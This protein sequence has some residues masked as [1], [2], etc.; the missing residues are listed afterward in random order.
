[1]LPGV[2]RHPT[3]PIR[4]RSGTDFGSGY[5]SDRPAEPVTRPGQ[6]WARW[7]A[8][9]AEVI[10]PNTVSGLAEPSTTVSR[11]REP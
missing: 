7:A 11:P 3:G 6:D 5:G 4:G 10:R 8:S 9:I 2:F 1:M